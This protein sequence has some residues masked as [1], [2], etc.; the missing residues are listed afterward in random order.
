MHLLPWFANG[1]QYSD[2][3]VFFRLALPFKFQGLHFSASNAGKLFLV[4]AL[5][6]QKYRMVGILS[7]MMLMYKS[8]FIRRLADALCDTISYPLYLSFSK[9]VLLSRVV[10]WRGFLCL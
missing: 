4:L 10:A 8:A 6:L 9:P 7:S 1:V 5:L 2:D 3:G